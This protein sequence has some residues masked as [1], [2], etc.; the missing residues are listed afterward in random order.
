MTSYPCDCFGGK[1]H[2]HTTSSL[3]AVRA[4]G[5]LPSAL[6]S[7]A[8]CASPAS[9]GLLA[10][11][12]RDA[13]AGCMW[14]ALIGDAL[15]HPLHWVYS[16]DKLVSLREALYGPTGLTAYASHVEGS[17]H[18][19]SAKYFSRCSPEAEPVDAF[20]GRPWGDGTWYHATLPPGD[21]TLTGR[22][23]ALLLTH[24]EANRALDARAWLCEY[25]QLLTAPLHADTWVDETHRVFLRN[26]AAGAEPYEAGMEDACLSSIVLALPLL[27]AYSGD[28]DA[29]AVATRVLLQLTHKSTLA[30]AQ[31]D[32]FGHLLQTLL[33]PYR[34][35]QN[36]GADA[37]AHEADATFVQDALATACATLSDDRTDL[38]SILARG[39]SDEEAYHGPNVVFSSR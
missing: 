26:L 17:Q 2:T 32:T 1:L 31:V 38:P 7:R 29:A 21:S 25:L 34:S 12:L 11:S 28:A 16:H 19:D 37:V 27:L 10:S 3:P 30:S 36:D 5:L 9:A 15:A 24:L 39:L 35:R 4:R 14:G 6:W 8:R 23:V 22:I 13:V 18:P 33:G 20:H